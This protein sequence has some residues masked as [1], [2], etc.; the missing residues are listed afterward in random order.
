MGRHRKSLSSLVGIGL[1][2]VLAAGVGVPTITAGAAAPLYAQCPA[3]GPDTGCGVLITIAADGSTTVATDP[4]QPALDGGTG[5]LVGIV[6]DSN[7]TLSSI[8]L[9]GPDSFALDGKGVCTVRPSPCFSPHEFG[10]TG[11]EGPGTTLT[12]TDAN[13]GTVGFTGGMG[14]QAQTYFSLSGSPLTVSAAALQADISV[15]A[16]DITPSTNI[17][18]SGQVGTFDVGNSDDAPAGDFGATV[19]WGDGTSS[20]ASVT[21]PDGPGTSYVVSGD[22]VYASPGTYTDT[23]TVT[24]TAITSI[25]NQGQASGTAAVTT[26]PVSITG[27][28]IPDQLA[29]TAFDG[30]VATFTSPVAGATAGDFSVTLDWG[31]GGTSAGTVTQTGDDAFDVTGSYTWATSNQ[32]TITIEVTYEGVT[33]D[34]TAQVEV[35]AVQTTV[36]C[37]GSCSGTAVT[38]D[39]TSGGSTDSPTGSLFVSLSDG[40][41]DCTGGTPYDY[42]PQITTVTTTGIP[43]NTVVH[44]HVTFLR[45]NLQGPY[46]APIEVCFASNLPFPVLG[47]GTATP[48][49][50]DGQ[51]YYVGLLPKCSPGKAT[52]AGPCLGH[53]SEPIPGWK[54]VVENVKF[55]AGDPKQR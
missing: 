22:H 33:T 39:Q 5:V 24:D 54:K 3:A 12:A 29:G 42:A 52:R 26:E 11:Y 30:E 19:D 31:D 18:F 25:T 35:D 44:V 46:G 15:A 48:Q 38:P 36:P 55:P 8:A 43:A 28:A 53:V 10:P 14:P 13:D 6:N 50:I 37:S 17:E 41:L 23:V 2:V 16:T 32:Y 47:G 34:G 9:S 21:Q 49:V 4:D 45:E 51:D 27:A 20:A 7:A 40:S 1:G